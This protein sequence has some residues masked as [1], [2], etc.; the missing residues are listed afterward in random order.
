MR[1]KL[2]RYLRHRKLFKGEVCG[3]IVSN[4][5]ILP[6]PKCVTYSILSLAIGEYGSVTFNYEAIYQ[7][8]DSRGI[9]GFFHTHPPGFRANPSHTDI[10]TMQAWVK[11]LA[12]PLLC[13][14]DCGW[15]HKVYLFSLDG[16]YREIGR[17]IS[18]TYH[19]ICDMLNGYV[20][21]EDTEK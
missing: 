16:S 10:G 15:E 7:I 2:R 13:T 4:I 1:D 19:P 20:V 6:T 9:Y 11:C 5:G 8:H 12:Q 18:P 21:I 14:I 17:V 3:V